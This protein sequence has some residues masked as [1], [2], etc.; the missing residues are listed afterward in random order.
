MIEAV[1]ATPAPDA[2]RP[3]A[4]ALA[5]DRVWW[6]RL[7]GTPVDT[8]VWPDLDADG[9]RA[10]FAETAAGWRQY[11]GGLTHD[12]DL[13]RIVRYPN[14]RGETFETAV[15]DVL[16]HVLLHAAHHRGQANASLR[17]AGVTPPVLDHIAWV[18]LGAPA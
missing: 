16:D 2:L 7:T 12:A 10:L 11:L 8:P 18:R 14:T 4:H 15:G 1:T 13:D 3:V 9:C 5:A 17:A 6:C